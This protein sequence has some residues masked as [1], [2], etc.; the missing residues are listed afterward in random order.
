MGHP[1]P[2]AQVRVFDAKALIVSS[3]E[4]VDLQGRFSIDLASF[5]GTHANLEVQAPGFNT[6]H[7]TVLLPSPTV[8]VDPIVL[9]KAL[10]LRAQGLQISQTPDKKTRILETEVINETPNPL[11]VK[12]IRIFFTRE[13]KVECADTSPAVL[14]QIDTSTQ[15]SEAHISTPGHGSLDNRALAGFI[16]QLPCGV[17]RIHL[18]F[19]LQCSVA[20]KEDAT[21]R[22]EIPEDIKV[23]NEGRSQLVSLRDYPLVLVRFF[24]GEKAITEVKSY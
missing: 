4:A 16:E 18:W 11:S 23:T 5:K 24:D 3:P 8:V 21:L 9:S 17:S 7:V 12:E 14:I 10:G 13:A 6:A 22:F 19:M 15:N 1:I 2:N 20:G